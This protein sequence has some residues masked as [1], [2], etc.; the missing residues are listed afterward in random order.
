MRR[1]REPDCCPWEKIET[2]LDELLC[3]LSWA[4][5]EKEVGLYLLKLHF[6][7]HIDLAFFNDGE[8]RIIRDLLF[9]LMEETKRHRSFLAQMIEELETLRQVRA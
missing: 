2:P 7:N 1:R 3:K 5:G 4:D 8:R 9:D 6:D